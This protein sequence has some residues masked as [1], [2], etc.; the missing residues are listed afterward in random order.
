M[1]FAIN[2]AFFYFRQ[3][4]VF[5]I[6]IGILFNCFFLQVYVQMIFKYSILLHS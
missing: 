3:D 6:K 5:E 2:F 4:F 1:N